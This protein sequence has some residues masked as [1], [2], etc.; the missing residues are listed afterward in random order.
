[1]FE[2]W[3]SSLFLPPSL[4]GQYQRVR[5]RVL[6]TRNRLEL[7]AEIRASLRHQSQEG[8]GEQGHGTGEDPEDSGAESQG[9]RGGLE[10]HQIEEQ[11]EWEKAPW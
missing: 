7:G 11:D 6:F 10:R 3:F 5:R 4:R 1:M 9:R 2:I 8:G